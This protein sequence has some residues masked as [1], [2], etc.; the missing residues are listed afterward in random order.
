MRAQVKVGCFGM[1]LWYVDSR[2]V[3]S[4]YGQAKFQWSSSGR[5]AAN[6][7]FPR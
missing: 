1:C 3:W 6:A 4:R 2:W 7:N 5:E